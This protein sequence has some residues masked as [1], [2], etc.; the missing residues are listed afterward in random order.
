MAQMQGLKKTVRVA[1]KAG[2]WTS[3]TCVMGSSPTLGRH[4][5]CHVYFII[6]MFYFISQFS[7]CNVVRNTLNR[8]YYQGWKF[9][10]RVL[11][12]LINCLP[13]AVQSNKAVFQRCVFTR[14]AN[15]SEILRLFYDLF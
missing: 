11:Y 9:Q 12:P 7:I 5:S 15:S 8:C 3:V 4:F 13:S 10:Y 1:Q 2:N 6:W 14:S